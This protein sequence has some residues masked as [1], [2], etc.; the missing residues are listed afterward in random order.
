MYIYIYIY[1]VGYV[2]TMLYKTDVLTPVDRYGSAVSKL[3]S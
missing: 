2:D 3:I 1:G